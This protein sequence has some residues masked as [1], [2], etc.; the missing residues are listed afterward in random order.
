MS[1]ATLPRA[2]RT[3]AVLFS[4]TLAAPKQFSKF[5]INVDG[6]EAL[7]IKGMPVFRSGTFADSM[8]Y[9]HTYDDLHM[10][11]FAEHFDLLRARQVLEHVPVRKGH[12]GF[13]STGSEIQDSIVGYHD[14][15]Y[16]GDA[17]EVNPVDGQK[18]TYLYA[19]YTIL[20]PE[21]IDKIDRGL[22]RNLSSEVGMWRTN[23]G[24][25]YWP[26]Y[27]GVAYVDFS[28]VDGLKNFSSAN[29]VG[30]KFSIMAANKEMESV[31]T[32]TPTVPTPPA[33]VPTPQVPS[34]PA[35]ATGPAFKF[36][37]GGREVEDFAS[38]QAHINQL[39]QRDAV[40]AA[41]RKELGESTRKAFAAQLATDNKITA[42]QIE[43]VEGYVLTLDDDQFAAYSKT[44]DN[45]MPVPVLAGGEGAGSGTF[46]GQSATQTPEQ[47][48]QGAGGSTGSLSELETAKAVV[49]SFMKTRSMTPDQ[50]KQ[51]PSFKKLAAAG[52]AP[53]L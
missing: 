28:A 7:Q 42:A 16:V 15:L 35:P 25:E 39:E 31:G 24:T 53:A 49:E 18:Y 13:M 19:D 4:S 45:A 2:A 9:E 23:N 14:A 46:S 17:P 34:A 6:K 27:Q 36:T 52:Q 47:Q 30:E 44:W 11:H 26:V 12:P 5:R 22:W 1:T 50:I 33:G 29:G 41:F 3:D 8:G 20:D 21:A 51:T 32:E 48:A 10:Q 37:I 43:S 38:V 40:N